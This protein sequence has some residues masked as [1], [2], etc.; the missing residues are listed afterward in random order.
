MINGK[1]AKRPVRPY[2]FAVH[3][4]RLAWQALAKYFEHGDYLLQETQSMGSFLPE[5]LDLLTPTVTDRIAHILLVLFDMH[6][7]L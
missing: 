2:S 7:A 5:V 4:S 3:H 6:R 1:W